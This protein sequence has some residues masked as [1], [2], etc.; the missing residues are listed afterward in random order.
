MDAEF[1]HQ[2]WQEN[3]ISFHEADGNPLLA[4]YIDQLD[5]GDG[6]R[7]FL[8]LCG[9]TGDIAWLLNRGYQVVGVE[10]SQLAIEQL[11]EELEITPEITNHGPVTR[12]SSRNLDIFVG[13]FFD[14]TGAILGQVDAVYDRAALV[15]LPERMRG[16]YAVH[17]QQITGNA[18]QLLICYN[19]D[20]SEMDGPPFS[21]PAQEV[22][23]H[24]SRHF[25]LRM[26]TSIEV[27]DGL[28]GTC[29][30]RETVWLL[31]RKHRREPS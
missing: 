11:F 24:Y 13:D 4:K 29:P 9:K 26:L 15:A 7:L 14:V 23:T 22:E 21:V 2:R 30:A 12:Y 10:L 27:A 20:P 8:P 17:L 31:H 6:A 28:R 18:P 3:T 16:Q 19:Y 1:W 25:T 5:L